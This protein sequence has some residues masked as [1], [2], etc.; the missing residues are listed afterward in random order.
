MP[1]VDATRPFAESLCSTFDRRNQRA[2]LRNKKKDARTKNGR[3]LVVCRPLIWPRNMVVDRLD[4]DECNGMRL[5]AGTRQSVPAIVPLRRHTPTATD[6]RG[7]FE[8]R[9]PSINGA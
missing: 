3:F 7:T 4:R 1:P 5:G 9:F 8:R 2:A 6:R